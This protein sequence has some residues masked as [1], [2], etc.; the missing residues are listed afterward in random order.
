MT[1]SV[2]PLSESKFKLTF[3]PKKIFQ[4]HT[5]LKAKIPNLVPTQRPLNIAI[6]ANS[7]MPHYHFDLETIDFHDERYQEDFNEEN[8]KVIRF[9]AIGLSG[10][11]EKRFNILNPTLENYTYE[12]IPTPRCGSSVSNFSCLTQQGTIHRGR[13]V[14]TVFRFDPQ[15]FGDFQMF[16][17]FHIPTYEDTVLFYLL[18]TVKKPCVYFTTPC[19]KIRPTILGIEVNDTAVLKNDERESMHFSIC[20][21]SLYSEGKL[22][23]INIQPLSGNLPAF[24]EVKM[25]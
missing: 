4:F 12:W 11:I 9:E 1:C 19:I 18:G 25:K 8:L 3:T 5:R 6:T 7:L 21:E 24:G 17:T 2:P 16:Y 23:K 13:T 14:E 22:H 15:D 10:P 20:K